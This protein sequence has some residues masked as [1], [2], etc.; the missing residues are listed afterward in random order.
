M[1]SAESLTPHGFS[2]RSVAPNLVIVWLRTSHGI[3]G[4]GEAV[5]PGGPY[6]A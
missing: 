4:I 1:D 6:G 5:V 2:V 3:E